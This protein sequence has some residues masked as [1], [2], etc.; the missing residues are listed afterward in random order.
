[1]SDVIFPFLK[2]FVDI[3]VIN[4]RKTVLETVQQSLITIKLEMVTNIF[5]V[6]SI[7]LELRCYY[8]NLKLLVMVIEV[9]LFELFVRQLGESNPSGN[10]MFKFINRNTRTRC[11]ICS[12]LTIKIPEYQWHHSGILIVNFEH[13]QHLLLVFLLLTLNMW[14]PAGLTLLK[15]TAANMFSWDFWSLPNKYSCSTPPGECLSNGFT[16]I[17]SYLICIEAK[18]REDL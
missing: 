6:F 16:G 3:Y 14:L 2:S 8:L 5:M 17:R 4:S 7:F 13:I 1:M 9:N 18:F 10:Y 12:K 15:E 11:E